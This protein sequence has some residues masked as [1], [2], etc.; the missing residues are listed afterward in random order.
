[1]YTING[2]WHNPF[3]TASTLKRSPF[4]H[5]PSTKTQLISF[6]KCMHRMHSMWHNIILFSIYNFVH[7]IIG[8]QHSKWIFNLSSG[9]NYLFKAQRSTEHCDRKGNV[10]NLFILIKVEFPMLI[11]HVRKTLQHNIELSILTLINWLKKKCQSCK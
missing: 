1:M 2:L 3:A 7:F 11:L 8:A 5:T 6:A 9:Y 10:I 4:Y